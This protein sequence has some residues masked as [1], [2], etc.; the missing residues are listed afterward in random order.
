MSTTNQW[1]AFVMTVG[2]LV[3]TAGPLPVGSL[4]D[5]VGDFSVSTWCLV[6]VTGVM[7]PLTPFWRRL[8]GKKKPPC[9]EHEG[10]V[11]E[12]LPSFSAISRRT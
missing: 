4:R 6:G 2:Y 7:L 8:A 11:L 9:V 3:A 1:N 5:R 10:Q 12:N